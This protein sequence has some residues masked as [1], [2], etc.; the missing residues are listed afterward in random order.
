MF[1]FF[2]LQLALNELEHLREYSPKEAAVYFLMGMIY[3]KLG[4]LHE[5][6]TH[7]T[8]AQDL[9]SKNTS[10]IK[11]IIDKLQQNNTNDNTA[12]QQQEDENN[13]TH[14]IFELP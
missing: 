9:D 3:R 12:P 1:V 11:S 4:N 7:L 14:D 13:N 5:A 2:I 6:M 8:V 10:L